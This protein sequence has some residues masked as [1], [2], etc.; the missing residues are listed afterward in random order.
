VQYHLYALDQFLGFLGSFNLNVT[1]SYFSTLPDFAEK[2]EVGI[3]PSAV[4]SVYSAMLASLERM[5]VGRL[6]GSSCGS[7]RRLI[8][9]S[10]RCMLGFFGTRFGEVAM[11]RTYPG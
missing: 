1:S 8:L 2:I 11:K 3:S 4:S 9:V 6:T 10:S 7:M 5:R